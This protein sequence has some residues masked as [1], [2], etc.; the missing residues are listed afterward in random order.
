MHGCF[1]VFVNEQRYTMTR[2]VAVSQCAANLRDV[3]LNA[4]C[5]GGFVMGCVQ[6]AGR[7]QVGICES[8]RPIVL[9]KSSW[10]TDNLQ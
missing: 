6:S 5:S 9:A 7:G 3:V 2:C 10:S 8:G 1:P 4:G